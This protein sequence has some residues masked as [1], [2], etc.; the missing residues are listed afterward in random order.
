[1]TVTVAHPA[2]YVNFARL[3]Q[4]RYEVGNLAPGADL[5]D[6]AQNHGYDSS[7]VNFV[8]TL[9]V[10]GDRDS[11]QGISMT[12]L[13]GP[14]GE[15]YYVLGGIGNWPGRI[16]EHGIVTETDEHGYYVSQFQEAKS[17]LAEIRAAE[18]A[19]GNTD[20]NLA[21]VGHSAGGQLAEAFLVDEYN[22]GRIGDLIGIYA[23]APFNMLASYTHGVYSPMVRQLAELSK[24]YPEKLI[25]FFNGTDLIPRL[26]SALQIPIFPHNSHR[27]T[28]YLNDPVT[29]LRADHDIDAI[30]DSMLRPGNQ[31]DLSI[32]GTVA[33]FLA[34]TVVIP[35]LSGLTA[36]DVT[37]NLD[38]TTSVSW[39]TL[40]PDVTTFAPTGVVNLTYANGSVVGLSVTIDGVTTHIPVVPGSE[41]ERQLLLFGE[42]AVATEMPT[43]DAADAE[44][45]LNM[46]ATV[47]ARPAA[48]VALTATLDAEGNLVLSGH[49]TRRIS[50]DPRDPASG[51][52]S[53]SQSVDAYGRTVSRDHYFDADE[54]ILTPRNVTR[55]TDGTVEIIRQPGQ[56]TTIRLVDS[57][58]GFDFVEASQTIISVFGRYLIGGD[59]LVQ[60]LTSA[61]LRT[62]ASNFGDILNSV[63]FD[64]GV[65]T[66]KNIGDALEG[67]DGEFLANLKTSGVGALSSYLMAELIDL[68]GLEGFEAQAVNSIAGAALTQIIGN[69]TEMALN[70]PAVTSP[71]QGVA[72]LAQIGNVAGSFLGNHLA[73]EIG[74]WDEIGE[75]LGSSIGG[76]LGSIA[77]QA[78]IPVPV[79]GAII[80]SFLGNLV[81]GLIGGVFT[82]TPKSGAILEFDAA[83]S[84][85][86][87]DQV[88]KE[89]G[90]S[91]RAASEL[92]KAAADALNGIVTFI[93]GELV[94][95]D[96]IA[97]GSYGMRGKRYVY[98]EDGTSSDN[99]IKFKEAED[100]IEYGVLDAVR[101][102]EFLGGDVY[103]KRAFY[104]TLETAGLLGTSA[105]T[106]GDPELVP[107]QLYDSNPLTNV[108]FGLDTLLGN[109]AVVDRLHAYQESSATINALI[110][111]EPDSAFSAEWMLAFARIE[112]LDL[113]RRSSHD[114][115]GGFT[116]LL[117]EAE[118]D[119]RAVEF[120]FQLFA[121]GINGERMTFLGPWFVGDTVDSGSKT[122]IQGGGDGDLLS[123]AAVPGPG[124]IA[125]VF[126]GGQGDDEILAGGTGDDLFGGDGDDRLVGGALDDW[127]LGG[128]G[129]DVLD[130]GEG[131]GNV[132]S[133]DSGEDRLVG[134]AGSDWLAGG[135]G[136]DRLSGGAG[137]DIFEGGGG[138]DSIDG[139]EGG[140]TTIYRPGDGVDRLS[141]R[142]S[143]AGDVD[144][145][146]FDWGIVPAEVMVVAHS[147]GETVSLFIG[148]LADGDRLDLRGIAYGERSGID[149]F[150][151]LDT[152]WDRGD[153]VSRAI[154]AKS[155]GDDVVGTADAET[156]AG[157][158]YDDSLTGGAGNDLL[159]GGLGSDVYTFS[160]GDGVDTI[161][162]AGFTADL[163]TLVFGAGIATTDIAVAYS[164]SKPRDLVVT[165]GAGGDQLILEDQLAPD[166]ANSIEQILFADGTSWTI[167]DLIALAPSAAATSGADT[168]SGTYRADVIAAGNGNDVLTGRFG[169]DNLDGGGGS[170]T[171]HYGLGD[172]HDRIH[173]SRHL[174]GGA[175]NTLVLGAGIAVADVIL[176][177]DH[178]DAYNIRLSFVDAAGSILIDNQFYTS[179]YG[180]T[181]YDHGFDSIQFADG[182]QWTRATLI[183]QSIV[184]ASTARSDYVLGSR[185]ADTIVA[186]AGNDVASAG[187][188]NDV[189]TGGLGNDNLDG[190][191]GSDAYHYALGDGD[192][193]IW[194]SRFRDNSPTNVLYLGTGITAGD[195]ILERDLGHS[196]NL[197]ITFEGAAGS[198]LL[199]NQLDWNQYGSTLYDDGIDSIQFADGSSWSRAAIIT[200]LLAQGSTAG[201]DIVSG[202]RFADTI[203]T[204]AGNDVLAGGDSADTLTGGLGNDSLDGGY[205]S[206]SYHYELGDGND[207]IVDNR[208]QDGGAVNT[209]HL[210]T[211]IAAADL[212][213]ER[214][215]ADTYNVRVTFA[216]QAG[217]ILLDNQLY[218]SDYASTRYD[219]GIDAIHFADGTQLSRA[220]LI[221]EL[222][223][224][225]ST[226][227][228]DYLLGTRFVDAV[229]GGAGADILS[230]LDSNDDLTGGLGD[231]N[232]DGGPGSDTYR[233]GLG[234]G[235]DRIHDDRHRDGGPTNTLVLGPGFVAADLI[236]DRDQA[237]SNNVRIAFAGQAGSILLDNQLYV[238]SYA[239]T[240]Y[241][242][243]IDVIQFD[244]G[245]SWNRTQIEAAI[246]SAITAVNGTSSAETLNGT[247]GR[248]NVF[249]SGGNDSIG[250]GAG[251]DLLRG[252]SGNDTYRFNLGDGFDVVVEESGTD[253]VLFGTGVAVADIVLSRPSQDG[254]TT[255]VVV[256]VAGTNDRLYVKGATGIESY[257]FADGTIWTEADLRSN[258]Y[259]QLKTAGADIIHGTGFDETI[260]G[261]AGAD[262]IYAGAGADTLSGS[263]GSD[264][265]QGGT[266]ND[267]YL[268]GR[269]GGRDVLW[270]ES[271]T[272][273]VRFGPDIDPA[274]L[275]LTRP[276]ADD[277]TSGLLISIAG[278]EDQLHVNSATGIERYE[279][280]DGTVW[281]E[282]EMRAALFDQLRTVGADIFHGTGYAEAVA[283]GDGA[284]R[285]YAFGGNDVVEGDAGNDV[286]EGGSGNDIYKF[287]L[288]DGRD[289]VDD[290]SGTDTVLFGAGI[291]AGDL[292]LARPMADGDTTGIVIS[293]AGT[294]DQLYVKSATGIERYEFADG[295]ILTESELRA[296]LFAQARTE[297]AD[298][299]WGSTLADSITGGAGS[300]RLYGS[301]GSD[302]LGG[303]RGEDILEGGSGNDAY[304]F[305][306]GDG[307]DVVW[308]ESG[309]DAIRFGPGIEA[310]DIIVSRPLQDGDTTGLFFTIRGTEDRLYVMSAAAIEQY[311]FSDGTVWTYASATAL[312]DSSTVAGAPVPTTMGD[313]VIFGSA[314]GD[315]IRG[316]GGDDVLRGGTGSDTYHFALG[317]GY[318]V[319][320]D[321]QSDGDTD[322]LILTGIASTTVRVI[323]SPADADDVVLFIDD[324]NQIYL[325]QQKAG[326]SGGIEQIQFSDGVTWTRQDI[327]SRAGLVATAGDDTLV[328]TN[329]GEEVEGGL[330]DDVLIGRAG[331]DSY[332]YGPGDG[333]DVVVE[334][335]SAGTALAGE[336]PGPADDRILFGA[337][338]VQSDIV[339]G[340][341][342][343]SG[344]VLITFAAASGSILLTGQNAGNGAGVEFLLF[345]GGGSIDMRLLL[346]QSVADAATGGADTIRG[347][348]TA[349]ELTGGLGDDLLEGG[350][351]A[352]RYHF[353]IG[354][355]ADVVLEGG[356]VDS[357][358]DELVLGTG[359]ETGDVSLR[360]T[361]GSPDDLILVVGTNGDEI[362]LT[363]QLSGR[364]GEG[365]E[366]VR[367]D[368]GTTWSRDQLVEHYRTQ[369]ATSDPDFLVGT[370]GDD[371]FSGLGG[372]DLIEGAAGD[373]LLGG[374]EGNDELRGGAGADLLTGG[375]GDDRLSGGFGADGFDG[376]DGFDTIDYAFSLDDWTVDLAAGEAAILSG[377]A[378]VLEESFSNIEAVVGGAGRD[379]LIG[380]A[381]ANRIEGSEGND[382][383]GG[384]DGNDVFVYRGSETGLDEVDGGS[385]TDRVEAAE[386]E[387]VIGLA[388]LQNVEQISGN[389]H[390]GVMLTGTDLA[391]TI[392]LAAVDVSG[393]SLIYMAAGN[394]LLIG[395]AGSD[396]VDLGLG[397]DVFRISGDQG[398]DAVT[399]GA[400]TDRVE[401][402]ADNSVIRLSSLAGVEQLAGVGF[403]NVAVAGTALGDVLNLANVTLT[404][405]VRV[406][407]GDGNDTLTGSAQADTLRG[408]GGNDVLAGGGGNDIFEFA[409]ETDGA[410]T[411]D[412]GSGTDQILAVT[413][414]VTIRLAAQTTGVETITGL[415]SALVYGALND[416]VNLTGVTLNGIVSIDA[417]SGNDTV[418]A[419]GAGDTILAGLGNDTLTGNG[420]D[421]SYVFNLGDG[422][423]IVQEFSSGGS[424]SG[425]TDA[426]VFGAGISSEDVTISKTGNDVILTIGASG[427]TL[428]LK[429]QAGATASYW[430][431]EVR[432]ADG[433]VWDRVT[434][435]TTPSYGTAAGE[436][437]NGTSGTDVIFG[438]GGNDTLGGAASADRLFGG[439]GAD[440]IVGGL[441]DDVLSGGA[442]DDIFSFTNGDG[443]DF[444]SGG[445]G[446]DIIVATANNCAIALST[447]SGIEEISTGGFSGVTVWGSNVAAGDM[448]DFSGVT[449][450]GIVKIDGGTGNDVL[451]GSAGADTLVGGS[452]ND[453]LS[454]H[455]GND[456]IDGGSNTDTADYSARTNAWTI[457]LAAASNHA[458]SG[459]ETDT[460]I[461][462]EN[463]TGGSGADS[464]TGSS[465]ANVL[466]GGGGDDRITGGAGNDTVQGGLGTDIAV[467]AG[468][469]AS[470]SIVTAGGSIQIVDN[471]T[472]TDGNDG[473]DTLAGVEIAEF[474]GGVQVS[475][476]APIVLDLDGDGVNLVTRASS[477]ADWDWSGDGIADRTGWVGGGDGIL[478]YDRNHDSIVSGAV[479]LSFVDDSA[480]AK[481]DLDGLAAFDTSRD[482]ALSASDAEWAAFRVWADRDGDGQ[483]DAGELLSMAEAR[484]ASISVGGEATEQS[485]GW[486]D[487]IV[488]NHGRFTRP[489]GSTSGIA[490]VAFNYV[491][492]SADDTEAVAA[493]AWHG[494]DREHFADIYHDRTWGDRPVHIVGR[495]PGQMDLAGPGAESLPQAL[496]AAFASSRQPLPEDALGDLPAIQ[497]FAALQPGLAMASE[498]AF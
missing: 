496:T 495:G 319:I 33:D 157:T 71:F 301:S 483:V 328:G 327:L 165:V 45:I 12:A 200:E 448:L 408:S 351:G 139:G 137:D 20:L 1:M 360:R 17:Y 404:G 450:T 424:G 34:R 414:G 272:D 175:T 179:S 412:G 330:G 238:T 38:G 226:G 85:F 7:F 387:T 232:L 164:S 96:E 465:A 198:I 237:D 93:G 290:E 304:A 384:G 26:G 325:D 203:A 97:A 367:F 151:F 125:N 145:L 421:D 187:D 23:F 114:W 273:T 95:G 6:L 305:N 123:A 286:L 128:S 270:D 119:A 168:L 347:F 67:M 358:G 252:G 88:W 456:S 399:G 16:G 91:K 50:H 389:G 166:G 43:V 31:F 219:H 213:L 365:V 339:V 370:G 193:R 75:Q 466:S 3:V 390:S 320:Y 279:F 415:G 207:R 83:T 475:L 236:L 292:R 127:L 90:G 136:A 276:H 235:H 460:L 264:L 338:I 291:E 170:D 202:T 331:G 126:N 156:L 491:R 440:T 101:D 76:A 72:N 190:G 278:T 380:D 100:L 385:G 161:A 140:D 197:R 57:P 24:Q 430:V 413:Q 403:A 245:T 105:E 352:D 39:H 54:G 449:M 42:G 81:G 444:V 22:A 478:V 13:R 344:D 256:A 341:G 455:L 494:L 142:G 208:H 2:D 332:L 234:D 296:S 461:A 220:A 359:I 281:T 180:F 8:N 82:G 185:F 30:I 102:F 172:G 307:R 376:G 184:Q 317:D 438:L 63:V 191:Y 282:A 364:T 426:L 459:S 107:G 48:P 222:F 283:G 348:F 446:Y 149:Q 167:R 255:G 391:E 409:S 209:L 429:S 214:D 40:S 153:L 355:G 400:G 436:T 314:Q 353:E 87:V 457:N 422:N 120:Q 280:E 356:G 141:D 188:G 326:A 443:Y 239:G 182:T 225:G 470:Y 284:D 104:N 268:F 322:T 231:D 124:H 318:D 333:D 55:V 407:G 411:V 176:A 224:Q 171:Y 386:D 299:I 406:D 398:A 340:H 342:T 65:A 84:L 395:A 303:G 287:D 221:T 11:T 334:L 199:D 134:R 392:D 417:G 354:D 350:R 94:N 401:A 479:E 378:P 473:T 428:T 368:D 129:N 402:G 195:L 464:I 420:G 259:T 62:L 228:A 135:A 484:V 218:W 431:E 374:G 215:P 349:D 361:P 46:D 309:T 146:E 138:A 163:D 434:T 295:T 489:D 267:T 27:L 445:A 271:G 201:T 21:V 248:D 257:E 29:G 73:S 106:G 133:G 467:F 490:D 110:A 362:R 181:P 323:T 300:D 112:E 4:F 70:N 396:T 216:G 397:D 41:L 66:T 298:T 266:G 394:D 274:D 243:G 130:A 262:K 158:I 451:I 346:A 210:G 379:T 159:A 377:A 117:Q 10:I 285:I 32:N 419:S 308:D 230:T 251:H 486:N 233:Y 74:N 357:I 37:H 416:N 147:S 316:K 25:A 211:G 223:N 441:G 293:V 115:D 143:A 108:E 59:E 186:G 393:L 488:I 113:W 453:T 189:L 247:A 52:F 155:A 183:A 204:G 492:G 150:S 80:G 148:D 15:V 260:D 192:D 335:G 311:I 324:S 265:L 345:S 432:F 476:A 336:E 217:S 302:V 423:D 9:E 206:D 373:D 405:I 103:A 118:V 64:S 388:S 383:L 196:V 253:K 463:V 61:T 498:F 98:W 111:A 382:L 474:K 152:G 497:P 89:D 329:F 315:T 425:G 447:L 261:G 433:T 294:A 297:G 454:G 160:L 58:I 427:E 79:I 468:L 242:H 28:S 227:H 369:P 437:M 481:S 254:D 205:G 56:P 78:L 249:G 194:D 487:N 452:G 371:G 372:D 439:E 366:L 19:N 363:G 154:F 485:W 229:Q 212:I 337:G 162:E 132:L 47:T 482:G 472:S 122:V 174:D 375:A 462:I 5:G 458:Q 177:R 480:G 77:G 178:A 240:Q 306:L 131:N 53:V 121:D 442:G 435:I 343:G 92:G 469:Q 310:G 68:V 99:R 250:G 263:A 275:I 312:L 173:D 418:I 144:S 86:V 493:P 289:V 51:V 321:P 246:V 288:G 244:D 69:L 60:V 36:L 35:S 18:A 49:T 277:D 109:F 44:E 14:Q 116:Y 410:D 477:H 258:L 313:D 241:K 381:Q 169:D 269:G 471:Q